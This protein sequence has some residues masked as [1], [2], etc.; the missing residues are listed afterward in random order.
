MSEGVEPAE[1]P[2]VRRAVGSA[3]EAQERLRAL[4]AC[5]RRMG[6]SKTSWEEQERQAA[7][8]YMQHNADQKT[9]AALAAERRFQQSSARGKP[10]SR[11]A[12]SLPPFSTAAAAQRPGPT[13][14]IL[15]AASGG[16]WTS[17][18]QSGMA[19]AGSFQQQ[20]ARAGLDDEG[21]GWGEESFDGGFDDSALSRI[22]QV[23]AAINKINFEVG[24]NRFV[25]QSV[26]IVCLSVCLSVGLPVCLPVCLSIY[27]CVPACLS[28]CTHIHGGV[29]F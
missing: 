27:I 6:L 3:K 7:L 5:E 29:G 21:S 28:V 12:H 23:A 22:A 26:A 18:M 24:E 1:L 9:H 2:A 8:H 25:C 17:A 19:S 16:D 15:Q 13:S 11:P 20:Q 14:H 10:S 4:A